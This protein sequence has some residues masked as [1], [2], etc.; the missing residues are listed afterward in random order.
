MVTINI[1]GQRVE[2]ED[3][4]DILITDCPCGCGDSWVQIRHK[5]EEIYGWISKGSVVG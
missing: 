4:D 5:R 1:N 3:G 2:V